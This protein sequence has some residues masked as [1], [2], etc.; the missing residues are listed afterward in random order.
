MERELEKQMKKVTA[1]ARG[2][3]LIA[4]AVTIIV[5][6]I[7]AGV[8]ISLS[9]GNNGIFKRAGN[10]TQVWEE[11][12]KNEQEEM[13]KAG[14]SIDGLEGNY[15]SLKKLNAPALKT[16]MTPIRFSEV[17]EAK[18]GEI[19]K[20]TRED[21]EWYSYED[22]KWANA[23]T[24]D[25]SMWVWIP[26]YAYRIDNS[27]KTTDVVFLIGTS[28]N[29]YDENGKLQTAKR[30]KSKDEKVDT[31]T[32]Y[33]VH[34][35]FTNESSIEY[36]NGGWD[37][38]LTGIWVSKFEAAYATSGEIANKAPVKE[39]SVV[40]TLAN[41]WAQKQE[42]QG[43]N[44][45]ATGDGS[46]PAR[47]W[48]DGVYEVNKEKIKYPTFQGSSYSMNYITINDANNIS[49]ALTEEGNIYGLSND[50]DSHLMKNSEWGACTYLARSKT[51]GIGSTDIA[52]NN[53]NLNNGGVSTTKEQGNTKASAYAVTGYNA[54]NNEWNDYLGTNVS[55]STTGN[56]YGIYDMS[57][58]TWERTA[59]YINNGKTGNGA[60]VVVGKE[61]STKYATVY[62][63]SD[64][65]ANDDEKGIANY[66]LNDKIYG[67]SVRETSTE[68]KGST[69]WYRD[70][71]YFPAGGHP[72]F[73]RGGHYGHGGD[74]GLS[75]FARGDGVAHWNCG[76]RSVLV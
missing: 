75:A 65:G 52:I 8:A 29:Y 1:K 47:N 72:F 71:S 40:Y 50:T 17:T 2:I 68:G 76:F 18:K 26:R 15:D 56:I 48:L 49:R 66:E 59:S 21:D 44:P 64:V 36:R 54:N 27:T 7:L 43:V 28:D 74:A 20:T 11:A 33:T 58:G 67:D 39:S 19:I 30:C 61:K 46:I 60:S 70:Y 4:L 41:V 51:Y 62:P 53:K 55:P 3:T 63:Y 12:S 31:T 42:V 45:D 35:A 14:A 38:E 5:L 69:S 25:G 9:I 24:Q 34:P 73:E 13:D 57:G 37:R 22:K 32:G 16:G 23:Q 6:L 10:A